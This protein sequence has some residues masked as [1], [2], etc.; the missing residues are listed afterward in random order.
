MP[1][2]DSELEKLLERVP[3]SDGSTRRRLVAGAI[4]AIGIVCVQWSSL[5]AVLADVQT[6][7][8]LA[9]P[10]LALGGV[11][12]IY[13]LGSIAEILGEFFL[14]RAAS[15]FFWALGFPARCVAQTQGSTRKIGAAVLGAAATPLIL[16]GSL[17]LGLIGRTKYAMPIMKQ[18][19]PTAQ[20]LYGKLPAKVAAGLSHPVGDDA[21]MAFK[22]LVDLLP[23]GAD[24]QW[25][26]R[27]LSKARDVAAVTTSIFAV[28]VGALATGLIGPGAEA[29]TVPEA[30]QERAAGLRKSLSEWSQAVNGPLAKTLGAEIQERVQRKLAQAE[31]LI[32][33]VTSAQTAG[34]WP[35]ADAMREWRTIE[36]ELRV[37]LKQGLDE[38]GRQSADK[39]IA[40][41]RITERAQ[42]LQIAVS[43]WNRATLGRGAAAAL[44]TTGFGALLLLLY[45]GFFTSLR[46]AL[47]SIVEAVAVELPPSAFRSRIG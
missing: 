13:A 31:D 23:E 18:L 35:L 47:V 3:Y 17:L 4:L 41:S 9:S 43:T 21:E 29:R 16:V 5:R 34:R 46:N 15:G 22:H 7:D 42:Q 28:A 37:D 32:D 39:L 25:A 26:R 30:V 24:R 40:T 33:F 1:L 14:V 19:T 20:D 6:K 27:L 44:Q 36:A 8:L 45:I 12:A 11:I 2:A 38:A 10:V